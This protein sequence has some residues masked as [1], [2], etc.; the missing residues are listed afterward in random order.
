[1][2]N[3]CIVVEIYK[4]DVYKTQKLRQEISMLYFENRCVYGA[5]RIH[6]IL[7]LR[8]FKVSYKTICAACQNLGFVSVSSLTTDL[9]ITKP[10]KKYE[11]VGRNEK[12]AIYKF[13]NSY[14]IEVHFRTSFFYE[15]IEHILFIKV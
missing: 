4:R 15:K 3:I 11:D 9:D 1:M 6:E 13:S 10:I 7:K 2:Y 5:R 8:G 12:S 14:I